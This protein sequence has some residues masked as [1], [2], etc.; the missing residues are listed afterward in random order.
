MDKQEKRILFFA[1]AAHFFAH[2]YI[3][4]FPALVMPMSR[5]LSV[6]LADILGYSFW[7][8]L[9]YGFMAIPW[10]IVSDRISHKLA[11]SS[12]IILSSL[13]MIFAGVAHSN[14]T[15]ILAFALVGLGCSSYH[16]A[17]TALVSQGI[18][19]RGKAL[20]IN[21]IWGTA[22]MAAAPFIMGLLNYFFMWQK[23]LIYIGLAGIVLGVASAAV[24]FAFEK[25]SDAKKTDEI[26]GRSV[27]KLFIM[28]IS[29]M[30]AAGFMYRSFTLILPAFIEFR[31]GGL[32]DSVGRFFTRVLPG[33]GESEAFQTLKAGILTT[34][35]YIFGIV[36]QSFGGRIADRYS[37][38]WAYF[39]FFV[40]AVPFILG[41][42]LLRGNLI[43]PVAG[44]F[45]FFILGMQPIENSLIAYLT[46]PHL[47]SLS[48]GI[49]FTLNFGIGS[50]AVKL[51]SLV[52]QQ[53]GIDGV[54]LLVGGFV[55][56]V[57]LGII[58]FLVATRGH[59][60]KH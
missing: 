44:M 17:G 20:G 23:S 47:R 15:L 40:A 4:V 52:E 43:I 46:P 25:G 37:L 49:K 48:Y 33:F 58:V 24:P 22:G 35:V 41:M 2:F 14:G 1:A 28:F 12:G 13:G 60:F 31:L 18:R 54:I 16:P 26:T 42:Y 32:N 53:A 9:L 59:S 27:V 50:F 34:I 19:E 45:S 11:L 55:L 51:T 3:L 39:A 10:G 56:L 36:G 5:A 29:I 6:P 7:M 57:I 21:G 8:Y 38:K 30:V